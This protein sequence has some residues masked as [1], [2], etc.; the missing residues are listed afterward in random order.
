[1]LAYG[2]SLQHRVAKDVSGNFGKVRQSEC[3][4]DAAVRVARSGACGAQLCKPLVQE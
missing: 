2:Q 4:W 3:V 1:M